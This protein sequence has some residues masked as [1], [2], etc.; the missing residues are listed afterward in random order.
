[1]TAVQRSS[2]DLIAD[3]RFLYGE[4]LLADGD[5][6][7]AA[8]LFEQ[9]LEIAPDWPDGHAG[10]ARARAAASDT[11]GAASAW[12]RVLALEPA[13]VLGARLHLGL[14]GAAEVPAVPPP[15]YVAA[16]FDQYAPDFEAALVDRL[17]YAAPPALAALVAETGRT[18]ADAVDL[19]CGTGL[20]G[21][22]VRT[23]VGRLDGI[24]L[25]AAMLE[26]AAA[27]GLY[28]DLTVGDVGTVL[29]ARPGRYELALAADVLC[30]LGDL[31]PVLGAVAR[32]LAPGGLFAF[33]IETLA[34]DAGE[35]WLLRPSLRYAH[36]PSGVVEAARRAGF[37]RLRSVAVALRLDGGTPVEGAAL[38]MKRRAG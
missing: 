20:M 11:D 5:A 13:D 29:A 31:A 1:M 3:R 10:L 19:G 21:A 8:E 38:L 24:D 34:E 16:L 14:L 28:D 7:V 4:G 35:D 12:R 32:S 23:S 9:A 37:D 33:T 2:G 26:Q 22:A 6:V 15:A 36:R 25:S 27:K 18:F 17:G 30:Y